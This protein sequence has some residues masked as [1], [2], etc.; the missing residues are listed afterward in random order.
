MSV[1]LQKYRENSCNYPTLVKLLW[2]VRI[3]A[4]KKSTKIDFL[5]PESAGWGGEVFHSKGWWSKSSCPPSKVC[6]PCQVGF[7]RRKPGTS[8]QNCW[9]V[10]DPWGSSKKF[11]QKMFMFIFRPLPMGREALSG[12]WDDSKREGCCHNKIVVVIS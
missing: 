10:P 8:R 12:S 11:V 2:M 5:G 1:F 3:Q 7:R 6:L 4:T 9:D